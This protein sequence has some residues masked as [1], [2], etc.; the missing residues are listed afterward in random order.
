MPSWFRRRRAALECVELVEVVTDYL[1]GAMTSRDR[2]RFEAH[3][4]A[5][6]GCTRYLA[7][8]RATIDVTGRLTVDDV[9]AL[10][11]DAREELI[12]AFRTYN[13]SS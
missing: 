13:A 9:D 1:E 12:A 5:C 4:G 8:M 2:A 3:L 10:G 6:P 11:A 7:Q